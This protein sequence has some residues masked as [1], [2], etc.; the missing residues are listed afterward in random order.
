MK[1]PHCRREFAVTRAEEISALRYMVDKGWLF[2]GTLENE[3]WKKDPELVLWLKRGW[4][5]KDSV[6]GFR[7]T[8]AGLAACS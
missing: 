1:C 7:I 3:S 5:E 2:A 6:K 4:I 8:T